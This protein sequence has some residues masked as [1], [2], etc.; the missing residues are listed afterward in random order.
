MYELPTLAS[1][2]HL[3]KMIGFMKSVGDVGLHLQYPQV[4]AGGARRWVLESFSDAGWS[5]NKTTRRSTSCGV[6]Y[7]NNCCMY[8]SSRSQEVVSLSSSESE[9]R[10]LISCACDSLFIKACTMSVLDDQLEHIIYTDSS[11]ARQLACRQGSGK[12]RHLSRNLC[13]SK[14]RR[15]MEASNC[16][17]YLL[18]VRVWIGVSHRLFKSWC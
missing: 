2:G 14:R 16:V 6:H 12:V 5:A 10:S 3:R 11:S 1:L 17:R 8:A 9:L 7:P 15:Q 13:E 18:G 4:N